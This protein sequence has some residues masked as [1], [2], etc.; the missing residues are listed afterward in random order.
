MMKKMILATLLFCAANASFAT[1]QTGDILKYAGEEFRTPV[2]P[3]EGRPFIAEKIISLQSAS[4]WMSTGNYRGYVAT[5]EVQG[6]ELY[7]VEFEVE[8][9][10]TGPSAGIKA[11][12]ESSDSHNKATLEF[13]FP[14]KVKNGRV[15]ADWFSGTIFTP[16]HR[17]GESLPKE[18]QREQ[19]AQ[20]SLIINIEKGNVIKI[21]DRRT[22]SKAVNSD[23]K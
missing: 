7:L 14:G 21:E 6:N 5:W 3:L 2:F 16:G 10:T 4:R 9:L 22:P 19:E 12:A 20:A 8:G 13:L 23:K 17:W 15:L 1:F 18:D 11:T